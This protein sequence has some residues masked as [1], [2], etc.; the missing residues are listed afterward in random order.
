MSYPIFLYAPLFILVV[1]LKFFQTQ[2][3]Y[4]DSIIYKAQLKEFHQQIPSKSFS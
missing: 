3:K 1:V 4:W 2:L